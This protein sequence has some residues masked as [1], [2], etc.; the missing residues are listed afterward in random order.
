MGTAG[1]ARALVNGYSRDPAPPPSIIAAAHKP[2]TTFKNLTSLQG[3]HLETLGS[4]CVNLGWI[5]FVAS[6][7]A[8]PGE[9]WEAGSSAWQ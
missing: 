2:V 3:L 1:F 9:E 8:L 5:A 4:C 6:A 7:G